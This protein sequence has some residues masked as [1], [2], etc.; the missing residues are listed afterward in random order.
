MSDNRSI[1]GFVG[2]VSDESK[3]NVVSTSCNVK[4]FAVLMMELCVSLLGAALCAL[5]IAL[6]RR[7]NVFHANLRMLVGNI[8]LIVLLGSLYA[9]LR[10]IIGVY[11][12]SNGSTTHLSNLML[13][14]DQ[15][16][17][18]C[19][20]RD[21]I[22]P[23]IAIALTMTGLWI[24]IERL[25]ATLNFAVYE[26]QSMRCVVNTLLPIIFY[27]IGF[28]LSLCVSKID[29]TFS[30]V[31]LTD[32]DYLKAN[33]VYII[34]AFF[35]AIFLILYV[36]LYYDNK[37][38]QVEYIRDHYDSFSSRFQIN[39]NI[40]STRLLIPFNI[41]FLL[42]LML[43]VFTASTHNG[44]HSLQS[45]DTLKEM[46]NLFYPLFSIVFPLSYIYRCPI[47][48]SKARTVAADM[49]FPHSTEA[50]KSRRLSALIS[51]KQKAHFELLIATWE[52]DAMK[53][54]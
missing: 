33:I 4:L 35:E 51:E 18:E 47:F 36:L 45:D 12:C 2:I 29:L 52:E 41:A 27:V 48:Y 7:F 38:R 46:R 44:D 50:K 40:K 49:F 11:Q 17:S 26:Y 6:L 28:L 34:A 54:Q 22:S 19:Y 21:S 15:R 25:Y 37:A 24:A 16:L 43:T 14:T 53:T 32:G 39:E 20:L 23:A 8:A 5:T 42:L 13:D 10:A 9:S 1:L 31:K 30:C 3:M